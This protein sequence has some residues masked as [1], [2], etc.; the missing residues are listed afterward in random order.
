MSF[1]GAGKSGKNDV[2]WGQANNIGMPPD[3]KVNKAKYL[4]YLSKNI[5][6]TYEDLDSF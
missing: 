4:T 1:R 3:Q 6:W 2:N 5:D